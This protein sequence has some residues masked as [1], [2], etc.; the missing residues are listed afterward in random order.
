MIGVYSMEK[1]FGNAFTYMFKDKDFKKKIGILSIF[2]F[3]IFAFF[4]YAIYL[5]ILIAHNP[6]DVALKI[7]E[8]I[9]NLLSP[10]ITIIMF[11]V[12]GYIFKCTHNVIKS[13]AEEETILLP[14]WQDDFF[15][16]FMIAAKK[17]GSILGI[18]TLLIPTILLLG[19]PF[20]IFF[21]LI[22]A[23]ERIFCE[24]FK[25][26]SFF[27]WKEA[28]QLIKNNIGL[29]ISIILTLLLFGLINFVLIFTMFKFKVHFVL[30]AII[31]TLFNSYIVL[32]GAYLEGIVGEKK[33]T[34]GMEPSNE[35]NI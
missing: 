6:K 29:Y 16:Y 14:N 32:V 1:S 15:S 34:K 8:P 4:G 2:L 21:I 7:K 22:L 33:K 3:I 26:D 19:I 10:I 25:F 23:L 18:Y 9:I 5:S 17:C 24:E 13:N 11:F 27:K 35:Q 20:I 12:S 31:M 28:F 30:I